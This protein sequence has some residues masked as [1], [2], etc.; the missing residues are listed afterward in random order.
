[1]RLV[2]F[3]AES[4]VD[5]CID[6]ALPFLSTGSFG[7][8]S[9]LKQACQEQSIEADVVVREHRQISACTPSRFIERNLGRWLTLG[10][11][12][13]LDQRPGDSFGGLPPNSPISASLKAVLDSRHPAGFHLTPTLKPVAPLLAGQVVCGN[14]DSD[15]R[16][17]TTTPP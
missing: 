3:A 9:C 2:H 10:S 8:G 5:R 15:R 11:L 13:T 14:N 7:T 16:P 12:Q 6:D 4:H 1:M 17:G